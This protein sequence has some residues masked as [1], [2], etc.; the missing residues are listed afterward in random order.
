[1]M[2]NIARPTP[3]GTSQPR[4]TSENKREKYTLKFK[5]N[6]RNQKSDSRNFNYNLLPTPEEQA[7]KIEET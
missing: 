2:L 3:K 7:K 6:Q 1:M 4:S 5:K